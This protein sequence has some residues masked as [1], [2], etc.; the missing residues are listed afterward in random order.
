MAKNKLTLSIDEHLVD[1]AK[2]DGL[3]ISGYLE[4]QLAKKYGVKKEVVWVQS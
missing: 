4:E 1:L 2:K 3:N